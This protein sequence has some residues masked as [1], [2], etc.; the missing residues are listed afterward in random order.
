MTIQYNRI[1]LHCN[2][3][4]IAMKVTKLY[5]NTVSKVKQ[6]SAI[7]KVACKEKHIYANKNSEILKNNQ[8]TTVVTRKR[9]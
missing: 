9:L 4:E 3:S 6:M 8:I 2:H 1:L 5:D 7:I